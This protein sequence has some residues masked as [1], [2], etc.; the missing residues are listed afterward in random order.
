MLL[1]CP[2][3][4]P[5]MQNPWVHRTYCTRKEWSRKLFVTSLGLYGKERT[6]VT[7]SPAN[8][9]FSI[10]PPLL[11][12]SFLSVATDQSCM[13]STSTVP[14]WSGPQV[15]SRL[16]FHPLRYYCLLGNISHTYN[17]HAD[18]RT[19][20]LFAWVTAGEI[21]ISQSLPFP[22]QEYSHSDRHF[23][24][25]THKSPS[26]PG[27]SSTQQSPRYRIEF[28]FESQSVAE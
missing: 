22:C 20:A 19:Y 8:S 15:H 10:L 5:R 26:S 17:T 24:I 25:N 27:E 11:L 6:E 28:P 1:I 18:T 3:L 9:V 7:L 13:H 2:L 21:A 14:F 16:G 23:S 4:R 12:C